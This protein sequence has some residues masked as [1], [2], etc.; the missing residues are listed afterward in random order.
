M[1]NPLR[2]YLNVIFPASTA[3]VMEFIN[4]MNKKMTNGFESKLKYILR[5]LQLQNTA[6]HTSCA[7]HLSL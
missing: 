6:D 7:L 4:A 1:S 2:F 3:D 5:V